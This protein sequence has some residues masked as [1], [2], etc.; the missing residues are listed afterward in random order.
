MKI[1]FFQTNFRL[2]LA[3]FWLAKGQ[4]NPEKI[5]ATVFIHNTRGAVC[6]WL[7]PALVAVA[8]AP[9][10]EPVEMD[11]LLLMEQNA[12]WFTQI[13]QSYRRRLKLQLAAPEWDV[14]GT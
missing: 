10:D 11:I 6:S 4:N 8:H 3:N 2:R 1:S 7:Q 14:A 9:P 13:D 5:L 12:K